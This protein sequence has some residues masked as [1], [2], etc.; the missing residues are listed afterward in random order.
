MKRLILIA[1]LLAAGSAQ[2]QLANTPEIAAALPGLG[3]ELTREMVGAT[4]QLYGPL[5]AAET[6]DGLSVSADQA[7]GD[8][9]RQRLDVYAPE[10]A[11]GLPVLLFAHGGGFVRGDKAGAANVARWFARHGVVAVAMNYR[12]A[13]ESTFPMGAQDVA[14]ALAWIGANIASLGGDPA[15]IVIA[16]NSA[17]SVH[18]G[19]YAFREELQIADDGVVGAILVSMPSANLGDHDL[20]PARDLLYFGESGDRAAQS[21]INALDGREIPLLIGY[22]QHEPALIASQTRQLVAALAARDDQLPAITTAM[23]HNHISIVEHI[24]S[25]DETMAPDMLEFIQSVTR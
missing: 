25:P 14:G 21:M 22:A 15:R 19:D 16:G 8:H 12:Y 1:A 2:A 23:G 3:A 18:I 20:D 4:M 11:Q 24:G 10:G 5:H 9:E 7:Y 13:P 6:N 17:G